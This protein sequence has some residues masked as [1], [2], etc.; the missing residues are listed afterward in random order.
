[1]KGGSRV[2]GSS[3]GQLYLPAKT[4]VGHVDAKSGLELVYAYINDVPTAAD[5][6]LE[7]FTTADHDVGTIAAAIRSV[8]VWTA[9]PGAT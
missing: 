5:S 1:M 9:D 4:Q 8:R 6:L 7:T 3:D 2:G